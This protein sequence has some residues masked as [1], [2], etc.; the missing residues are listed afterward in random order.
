MDCN[1]ANPE[2]ER[3]VQAVFQYNQHKEVFTIIGHSLW[4]T[5]V[6]YGC[7]ETQQGQSTK[8]SLEDKRRRS[9]LKKKKGTAKKSQT[10][11]AMNNCNNYSN[12]VT[13]I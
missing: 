10:E 3:P 12:N 5:V 11:D 13:F 7:Q 4:Q 2:P 1:A 9:Q 8:K 6:P